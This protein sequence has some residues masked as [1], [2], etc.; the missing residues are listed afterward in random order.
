MKKKKLLFT[1]FIISVITA[2]FPAVVFCDLVDDLCA[3]FG[4][5]YRWSVKVTLDESYN[6]TWLGKIADEKNIEISYIMLKNAVE[7]ETSYGITENIFSLFVVK[8]QEEVTVTSLD[9]ARSIE[10]EAGK[11]KLYD[12]DERNS[13]LYELTQNEDMTGKF[14][15]IGCYGYENDGNQRFALI[16][17]YK[18]DTALT[19]LLYDDYTPILISN[20]VLLS[21]EDTT[22]AEPSRRMYMRYIQKKALSVTDYLYAEAVVRENRKEHKVFMP[23]NPVKE[24]LDD[25]KILEENGINAYDIDHEKELEKARVYTYNLSAMTVDG[26]FEL[27]PMRGR[28][29]FVYKAH[30]PWGKLEYDVQVRR[31]LPEADITDDGNLH[32]TVELFRVYRAIVG[33]A[34]EYG[35]SKGGF[36]YVVKFEGNRGVQYGYGSVLP[37]K[38]SDDESE[39]DFLRSYPKT[40][41]SYDGE[42]AVIQK[43]S[44]MGNLYDCPNLYF[45]FDKNNGMLMAVGLTFRQT[46]EVFLTPV[47]NTEIDESFETEITAAALEN[48][49]LAVYTVKTA[50]AERTKNNLTN[51]DIDE[52]IMFIPTPEKTPEL[53]RVEYNPDIMFIPVAD[54]T[55]LHPELPLAP[56]E[57]DIR[58]TVGGKEIAFDVAPQ[59]EEDR[60]LVPLR[61]VFEQLG[62]FVDWNEETKTAKIIGG[63]IT[64]EFVIGNIEVKVNGEEKQMDIPAKILNGRTLVPMRFLSEALG[65][66]VNWNKEARIVSVDK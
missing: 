18:E 66:Q 44:Y 51:V 46:D 29:G 42:L 30:I 60:V 61:A 10:K 31:S 12:C 48:R 56:K 65:Y 8:G 40:L 63:D 2:L 20:E 5:D 9:G 27:V 26:N 62:D 24:E 57:G 11:Y 53:P 47:E 13:S 41:K 14:G 54:D 35:I 32:V 22:A 55:V 17:R 37:G 15:L 25:K 4:W 52:S 64:I 34:Q 7:A 38:N 1:L 58:I 3:E 45:A 23:L 36:V 43:R 50:R 59:I 33:E 21:A 19:P 39:Y 16:C 6:N 28:V 49:T